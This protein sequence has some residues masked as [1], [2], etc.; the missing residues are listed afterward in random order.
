MLRRL[1]IRDRKV[2][3]QAFAVFLSVIITT[4]IIVPALF[5]GA[6]SAATATN[7]DVDFLIDSDDTSPVLSE[8]LEA[9]K[10]Y[11]FEVV[12]G[13]QLPEGEEGTLKLYFTNADGKFAEKSVTG[14]GDYDTVT[15]TVNQRVPEATKGDRFGISG[16]LEAQSGFGGDSEYYQVDSEGNPPTIADASPEKAYET[17][18]DDS[19]SFSVDASDPDGGSLS[20]TWYV[21]NLA[22]ESG[23]SEIGSGLGSSITRSFESPGDYNIRVDI[24]DGSNHIDYVWT[25]EVSRQNQDRDPSIERVSPH[26]SGF[27]VEKDNTRRF[28]IR[29]SDPDSDLD[30]IRWYINGEFRNDLPNNP[31]S[32]PQSSH[33]TW[34]EYTFAESGQHN[35][36]ATVYDS[37]GN[38]DSVSWTVAVEQ[39]EVG[40]EVSTVGVRDLSASSTILEGRLDSLGSESHST[41]LFRYRKQGA[42]EWKTSEAREL[43]EES[44]FS[45]RIEGLEPDTEYELRA[46]ASSNAGSNTGEVREFRTDRIKGSVD[47]H[48]G[49]S[50]PEAESTLNAGETYSYDIELD[51]QLSG[52]DGVIILESNGEGRLAY[53]EVSRGRDE[54]SI[55]GKETVPSN[56]ASPWQVSVL[57]KTENRDILDVDEISYDIQPQTHPPRITNR[58]PSDSALE[59]TEGDEIGFAVSA[60]DQDNNFLDYSWSITDIN[61][62]NRMK[63]GTGN[64]Y[65]HTFSEPGDYNVRV[66]VSDGTTS[67]ATTWTVEVESLDRAPSVQRISPTDSDLEVSQ[68]SEQRFRAAFSDPD[69][70]LKQVRWYIDGKYR[71]S[72][73]GNPE[74]LDGSSE[75]ASL[76]YTFSEAGSHS[77]RAV[78][79]D[80]NGNQDSVQWFVQVESEK[81]DLVIEDISW[82]PSNPESGDQ[83]DFT[84]SITNHGE[85]DVPATGM[86]LTAGSEEFGL[87]GISLDAGETRNVKINSRSWTAAESVE[88][89]VARVDPSNRV[90]EGD[91]SNNRHAEAISVDSSTGSI[92][93]RVVSNSGDGIE[94]ATINLKSK[95]SVKTDSKGYFE[96]NNIQSGAHVIQITHSDFQD[97]EKTVEVRADQVQDTGEIV[98]VESNQAQDPSEK[99]KG[100]D[101]ASSDE[102]VDVQEIIEQYD[103]PAAFTRDVFFSEHSPSTVIAYKIITSDLFVEQLSVTAR[104]AIYGEVGLQEDIA[105]AGDPAYFAGWLGGSVV[106]VADAAAD[107]RDC[108]LA[109]NDDLGTNALDCGGAAISTGGSA[110]TIAGAAGVAV[111]E[112]LTTGSGAAVLGG[113]L[114]L[115]TAEDISDAAHITTQY[116]K[117]Y[118]GKAR[119]VTKKLSSK[120]PRNKVEDVIAKINRPNLKSKLKTKLDEVVNSRKAEF[121]K[122]DGI[123][124][125]QAETLAKS[126]ASPEQI[127]R[128]A[129]DLDGDTIIRLSENDLL[130][131]GLDDDA[132]VQ[133]SRQSDNYKNTA[134]AISALKSSGFSESQVNRLITQGNKPQEA[135]RLSEKGLDAA[136]ITKISNNLEEASRQLSNKLDERLKLVDVSFGFKREGNVIWMPRTNKFKGNKLDEILKTGPGWKHIVAKHANPT[137]TDFRVPDYANPGSVTS[138]YDSFPSSMGPHEMQELAKEFG[139]HGK[140]INSNDAQRLV[141]EDSTV[142]SRYNIRRPVRLI[143]NP[144]TGM[145]QTMYIKE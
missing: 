121:K 88:N 111:P 30:K 116:L 21:N 107:L 54:L 91:E 38:M 43:D 67:V 10:V 117:K 95:I 4:S 106:P 119:E 81:P 137:N 125:D 24:T 124:D 92:Q 98:L 76:D 45:I 58:S 6:T 64:S 19:V 37:N 120:L 145:I 130:D 82:S 70:D 13:Y 142:L 71:D 97:A 133:I 104:G 108:V 47:I 114:T 89:V 18:V 16:T 22:K 99:D 74:M 33:T 135:L 15:V 80:G 61:A 77:I 136:S 44:D 17:T 109:V 12:V 5:V 105:G 143:R 73:G 96:I 101:N 102:F 7:T 60:T 40:P 31:N 56:Q 103:Y 49:I 2:V 138:Q 78:V 28:E 26:D 20:Y 100:V 115:D 53:K 118:P 46:V 144:N 140:Q 94:D 51:Y 11:N 113:S 62:N 93:G 63:A 39:P 27:T 112:P 25:L 9:G 41:V 128:L 79:T 68:D 59:I 34:T 36:R 129:E 84:V 131:K 48:G 8:R 55:S 72:L 134:E 32:I 139:R 23:Y 3:K 52:V 123:S 127:R 90:Q 87:S 50:T 75:T 141:I 57:L 14:S 126:G 1:G 122:I 132:L 35:V 42:V 29:A 85:V 110:G 83:V 65:F 86:E 69:S 66:E